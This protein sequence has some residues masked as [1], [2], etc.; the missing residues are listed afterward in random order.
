ME[1]EHRYALSDDDIERIAARL[2]EKARAAFHIDEEK[3]YNSHQ[4]LDKLLD[5]YDNAANIFI[6]TFLALLI[7]GLIM[8]AGVAALKGGH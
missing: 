5:A 3:H 2:A 8:L 4:R 1:A 7:A 6:K